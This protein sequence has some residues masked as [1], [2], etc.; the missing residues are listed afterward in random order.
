MNKIIRYK[1]TT[2]KGI[3]EKEFPSFQ[4]AENYAWE[5]DNVGRA[6]LKT[7]EDWDNH[8]NE[9]LSL[10]LKLYPKNA[11]NHRQYISETRAGVKRL[12]AESTKH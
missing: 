6:E 2:N 10:R 4:D 3:I 7:I 1:F 9:L 12:F 5:K 8:L 11:K